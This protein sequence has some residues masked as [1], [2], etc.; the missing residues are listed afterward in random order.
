MFR[1]ATLTT[2][3]M[4]GS[5]LMVPTAVQ[6]AGE[7]C[8]GRAATIV[9]SPRTLQLTGTDGPD[10][11][12]T[13]GS[14]NVDSLGGD[15][16]ICV[17]ASGA[18]VFA[19]DGDDLVD[20]SSLSEVGAAARLGA[21]RDHFIGGRGFDVV[22]GGT[23][24]GLDQVDTEPDLIETGPAGSGSFGRD[25]VRSGQAGQPNPDVVRMGIGQLS[26]RGIPAAGGSLDGGAGSSLGLQ[27]AATDE[28]AIDNRTETVTVP[29]R[30]TLSFTG[31]TGFS[32]TAPARPRAFSFTGSDRDEEL[33]LEFW[34]AGPH[35]VAMGGGDDEVH[36]HSYGRR[37]AEAATYSGGPGR[38]ELR[39]TLPD[40]VDL[41]LDL[42]RGRL[43][44]G[45]RVNEVTVPALGFEDATVMAE[46]VEVA[47][48]H[49]R[50]DISVYACRSRVRGRAGKDRI[51]TF[52]TVMDDGLRCS[53]AR[54]TFF[55]G[56]G[57]DLLIGT[58]GR[59][60]LV[61][62]PGHDTA[63]GSRG[64]DTC[65]AEKTRSCEKR[66]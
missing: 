7:T 33:S 30:P 9:G 58:R 64:R 12:V 29:G 57:H 32:V 25:S 16:V 65:S 28:I 13:N 59:D 20:S 11:I 45:P 46:D 43:S 31:F 1:T 21:G 19:G 41:D 40:E 55:G 3:A 66:L 15:D 23:P 48:T 51:D 5:M 22:W 52:D 38:D 42:R 50:N 47:G 60:R 2:A 61:G 53:G 18:Q 14:L 17:T 35:T 4:I 10:V 37:A 34:Q 27:V 62:G 63:R 24:D 36:Y 26:W 39:L 6:A 49:G 54:A 8:H 44:L 56:R